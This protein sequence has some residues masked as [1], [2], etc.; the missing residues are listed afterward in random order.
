MVCTEVSRFISLGWCSNFKILVQPL[1][2]Q[3]NKE[4]TKMSCRPPQINILPFSATVCSQKRF[5]KKILDAIRDKW[6]RLFRHL[7]FC[8]SSPQI[9]SGKLFQ[10]VT[11]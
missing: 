9:N 4:C 11:L 10:W 3:L 2:K 1:S 5:E 7:F 6:V 8:T